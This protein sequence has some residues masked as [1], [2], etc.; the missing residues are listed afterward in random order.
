MNPLFTFLFLLAFLGL[1]G[2]M[3]APETDKVEF[4]P[5]FAHVVYFWL[6][7]PD[8]PQECQEFEGAAHGIMANSRY[9]KT[10]FWGVPPGQPVRWWMIH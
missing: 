6:V 2:G 5:A 7:N 4:H 1:P 9:T 8:N 10:N 3:F